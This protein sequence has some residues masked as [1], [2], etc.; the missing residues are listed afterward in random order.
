M[1]CEELD[2][3]KLTPKIIGGLN[4]IR[5]QTG[6]TLGLCCLVFQ[7]SLAFVTNINI[8]CITKKWKLLLTVKTPGKWN[9]C[10]EEQHIE[11]YWKYTDINILLTQYSHTV[12]NAVINAGP[13][14]I[15]STFFSLNRDWIMLFMD[16]LSSCIYNIIL[17]ILPILFNSI[18]LK[19]LAQSLNP[20]QITLTC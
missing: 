4:Y 6:L 19:V 15:I 18:S 5:I 17:S 8:M 9:S 7:V 16:S 3:V 11:R 12:V 13:S 20:L 10:E 1:R 14:E 2:G